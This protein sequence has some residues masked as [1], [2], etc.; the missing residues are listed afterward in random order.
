MI[1]LQNNL[2]LLIHIQSNAEFFPT[3][4]SS[5]PDN[6]VGGLLHTKIHLKL[7]L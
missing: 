4:V 1:T 7:Y 6:D 5:I 2:T 3:M